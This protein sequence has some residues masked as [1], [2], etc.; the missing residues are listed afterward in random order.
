M[1]K[2]LR[3]IILNIAAL[4]LAAVIIPS[5]V[6]EQGIKTIFSAALALTIFDYFLKPIARILFLPINLLTLGLLRWIIN[7][8]S[9]YLITNFIN[10][11]SIGFYHFPGINQNG[12]IIPSL[13]FSVPITYII[14]SFVINLTITTLRWVFRNG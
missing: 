3:T 2:L 13:D 14:T 4:Y 10:D 11:F 7:V 5:I 8:I 6:F 12:F 9:L 1:K